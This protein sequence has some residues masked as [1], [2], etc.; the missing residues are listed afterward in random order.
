MLV[1][2]A[3]S[4]DPRRTAPTAGRAQPLDLLAS[5]LD[6]LDTGI[7]LL[8]PPAPPRL[9]NAAARSVL[10]SADERDVLARA[11][12]SL[13]AAVLRPAAAG[14]QTEGHFATTRA[15]Y[16]MRARALDAR[17]E[18][19]DAPTVMVVIDR[20]ASTSLDRDALIRRFGLTAREADVAVQLAL[21][22]RNATIA[23]RLGISPH[24]THHYTE[25]VLLKLGVHTRAEVGRVLAAD[26]WRGMRHAA[27]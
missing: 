21:G 25:S 18:D 23:E 4:L 10:E 6:R 16:W 17:P 1:N 9:V 8:R 24:T 15:L 14:A 12:R 13:C 5:V 3:A 7:V 26:W 20:V 22:S 2:D 19:A 27:G 11:I